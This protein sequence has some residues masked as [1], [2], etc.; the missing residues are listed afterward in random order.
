MTKL[1]FP[2]T[3]PADSEGGDL[4]SLIGDGARMAPHWA[5]PERPVSSPVPP[6]L[7]HGVSV[8]AAS[9]RLLEAMSDY[10]D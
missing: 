1:D 2:R 7:I 9:A 6:S 4:A 8:P 5:A 3:A 10:G